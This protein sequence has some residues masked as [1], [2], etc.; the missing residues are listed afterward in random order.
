MTNFPNQEFSL[1]MIPLIYIIFQI[2]DL[3]SK[4]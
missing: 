3:E 1:H 4:D 2:Y